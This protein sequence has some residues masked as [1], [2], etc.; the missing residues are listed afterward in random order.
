MS[1]RAEDT[2]IRPGD[3]WR[4]CMLAISQQRDKQRFM[5]LYD[6]FAPRLNTYLQRQGAQAG[7]AEELVQESLLM[8]WR[9][10][11]LYQPDKAAVSTWLFR[12]ARNLHIDSLRRQ[13]GIQVPGDDPEETP[14]TLNVSPDIQ[15]D[16]DK[17]QRALDA[18]PVLQAQ[19]VYK[20]YFE[21]KS[22]SEIAEDLGIPLGSVK[23]CL[24][25]AFQKLRASMGEA[26]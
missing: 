7:L 10:A 16:G 11:H 13:S 3:P 21:T 22:H 5:Q 12:I 6:H 14:D 4:D 9:K 23:S 20:S 2:P 15:A 17:V 1:S 18:L 8:L 24:R 19:V 26:V 25:L